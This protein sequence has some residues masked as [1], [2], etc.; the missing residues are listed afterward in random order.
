MERCGGKTKAAPRQ[1]NEARR[2]LCG[3]LHQYSTGDHQTRP[4]TSQSPG[5]ATGTEGKKG[6][7]GNLLE[8]PSRLIE[9]V[10]FYPYSCLFFLS[11]LNL[12]TSKRLKLPI[13]EERH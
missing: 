5:S 1:V 7:P 2:Q 13:T 3:E 8:A 6:I 11:P 12:D 9:L 4:T 10:Q